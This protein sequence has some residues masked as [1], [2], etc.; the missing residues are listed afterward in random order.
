MANLNNYECDGQLSIFDIDTEAKPQELRS[1]CD[2]MCDCEWGSKRCFEKRGYM[3]NWHDRKWIRD[4]DGQCKIKEA[5]ECDWQPKALLKPSPVCSKDGVC[6]IDGK[7]LCNRYGD[8]YIYHKP[9]RQWQ[10]TGCCHYC[11]GYHGKCTW[12][13]KVKS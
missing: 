7:S 8:G 11:E 12:E 6:Q 4:D 2:R 13:C 1:P 3:W 9:S 10:C 5:R